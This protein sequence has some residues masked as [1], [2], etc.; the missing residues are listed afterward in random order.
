MK[1]GLQPVMA[2]NPYTEKLINVEPLFHF[3]TYL[4]VRESEEFVDE[5]IRLLTVYATRETFTDDRAD[6]ISKLYMLRDMFKRLGE[7]GISIP[8]R[9]ERSNE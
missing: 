4:D 5:S 6:V 2:L 8:K 9:N 7:C 1:T 3:L